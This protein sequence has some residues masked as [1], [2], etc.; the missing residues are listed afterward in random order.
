M[1]IPVEL[2]IAIRNRVRRPFVLPGPA[3]VILTA[4]LATDTTPEQLQVLRAARAVPSA[5]QDAAQERRQQHAAERAARA[6]PPQGHII[7]RSAVFAVPGSS[8]F[9]GAV[10][11]LS[12]P[13]RV[14]SIHFSTGDT[15]AAGT[16]TTIAFTILTS[17]SEATDLASLQRDNNLAILGTQSVDGIRTINVHTTGQDSIAI[18]MPCDVLIP[19]SPQF[20]KF[21]TTIPAGIGTPSMHIT[22][23]EATPL[24]DPGFFFLPSAPRLNITLNTQPTQ[25]RSTAHPPPRAAEISVTQAGRILSSRIVAWESLAPAIRADWFN[26]QVGGTPDPNIRW[27]P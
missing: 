6:G 5:A 3:P 12:F 8:L 4:D 14:K 17:G 1:P 19:E 25:I 13:F 11:P 2:N 9:A 26:R 7:T 20:V 10:G 22:I 24:L 15:N 23:E 21:L 16:D 27:I 18:V